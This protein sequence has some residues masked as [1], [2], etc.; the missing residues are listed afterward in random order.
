MATPRLLYGFL[1]QSTE[2][3]NVSIPWR[4]SNR[5]GAF[6]MNYS[7]EAAVQDDLKVWAQ[8]NWGERPMRFR[9]GLDARRYVFEPKTT[10]KQNILD[11]AREQLDRY[12]PFLQ[13]ERLDV[14]SNEDDPN[15]SDYSIKFIL[16]A[17]FKDSNKRI[18]ISE[19]VGL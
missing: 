12:F 10:A 8:T 3:I 6:R 5:D 4:V 1:S 11:N 14:I 2:P 7:L 9:F 16:E 13:I 18:K 19:N 15:L 17:S